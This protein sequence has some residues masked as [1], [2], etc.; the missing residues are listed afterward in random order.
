MTHW[1][2]ISAA[3]DA[4]RTAGKDPEEIVLSTAL[5]HALQRDADPA[6]IM[7]F[8]TLFGVPYVVTSHPTPR[9][10]ARTTWF[11]I[12]WEHKPYTAFGEPDDGTWLGYDLIEHESLDPNKP[13]RAE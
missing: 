12:E 2:A 6:G 11:P 5:W 7:T 1:D 9:V 13:R 8:T 4:C 3:L 10:V